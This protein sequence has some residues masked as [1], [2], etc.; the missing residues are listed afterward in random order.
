MAGDAEQVDLSLF[1]PFL[2]ITAADEFLKVGLS[3]VGLC[4]EKIPQLQNCKIAL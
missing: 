4:G 3:L 1:S 2:N